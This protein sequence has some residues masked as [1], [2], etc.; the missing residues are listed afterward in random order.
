MNE[1]TT[2][3][4]PTGRYGPEPTARGRRAVVV[5]AA[6]G[7]ALV[8]ALVV[9]IGAGVLRVPVQWKDVGYSVRGPERID[10]TFDVIKDPAV[11]VE[12][13]I[14]ALSSGFAEV[15]VLRVS[16]GPAATRVQRETVT[17][18]TQELA[19]TGIVDSCRVVPDAA[20]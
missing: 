8:V 1:S 2:P 10:V 5:A 7:G 12:C 14:H 16:V 15:G 3:R 9:W 11:T 4:T 17:V 20:Q 19:V 18:A 13:T 6:L